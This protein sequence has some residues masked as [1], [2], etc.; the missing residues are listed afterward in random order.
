MQVNDSDAAAVC[1][2]PQGAWELKCTEQHPGVVGGKVTP[3]R[4][5]GSINSSTPSFEA[6]KAVTPRRGRGS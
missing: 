1:H 6:S 4:G 5:R 3:R 2:A